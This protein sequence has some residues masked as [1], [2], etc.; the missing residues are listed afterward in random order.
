[1]Y[2]L[3]I[4]L[5]SSVIIKNLFLSCTLNL[6]GIKFVIKNLLTSELK[7]LYNILMQGKYYIIYITHT[8]AEV[9]RNFYYIIIHL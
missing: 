6:K 3:H 4:G 8:A 1:M 9:Y 2:T 7:M 5:F